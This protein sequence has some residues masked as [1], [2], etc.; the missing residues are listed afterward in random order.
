MLAALLMWELVF[1]LFILK[2]P[3]VYVAW[4]VWWAI[5]AEPEF[6]AEG[7]THSF[8]WT[9]WRPPSGE[10]PRRGSPH[11][12]PSRGP[13]VGPGVARRRERGHSS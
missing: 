1:M 13:R 12:S 5:K 2:L 6:G 3:V 4:I 10:R 11:G 7:E 9:P 8:T